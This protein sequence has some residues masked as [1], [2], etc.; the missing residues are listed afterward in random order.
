MFAL[1][2]V[3]ARP[4]ARECGPGFRGS[5]RRSVAIIRS[6]RLSPQFLYCN[7]KAKLGNLCP[8]RTDARVSRFAIAKMF[9]HIREMKNVGF[10][11]IATLLVGPGP[12][13]A[14]E[15][16]PLLPSGKW[17]MSGD[18][19]RCTL[20][21]DYVDHGEPVTLSIESLALDEN[22]D[23]TVRTRRRTSEVVGR[24]TKIGFGSAIVKSRIFS[25]DSADGTHRVHRFQVDRDD[26][27]RAAQGATIMLMG[28]DDADKNLAVPLLGRALGILNECEQA[29][30]ENVGLSKE[31]VR[32]IA[33]PP[34]EPQTLWRLDKSYFELSAKGD[35]EDVAI[36]RYI[37]EADGR[38]GSCGLIHLAKSD[39]LNHRACQGF[40][41]KFQPAV[42]K[43][44][45]KV[46]GLF[47][48]GARWQRREQWKDL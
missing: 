22:M 35:L 2:R 27:N 41:E 24:W 11:A 42:D 16:S 7:A 9:R 29:I 3:R 19:G 1:T 6:R 33:Q 17:V 18:N 4:H 13:N 31:E 5:H 26:I 39:W 30:I 45:H 44:G 14:A 10:L 37:I 40:P 32:A 21:R 28:L 34:K 25:F 12:I 15:P 8:T 48:T 43:N 46:R 23:L 47:F 36:S 20:S 38:A